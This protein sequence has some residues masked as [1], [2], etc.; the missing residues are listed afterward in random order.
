[1]EIDIVGENIAGERNQEKKK[2]AS[3]KTKEKVKGNFRGS[4]GREQEMDIDVPSSG[5][6]DLIQNACRRIV[7][8]WGQ[9]GKGGRRGKKG[10]GAR[11]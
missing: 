7:C 9:G 6:E 5:R 11:R 4:E 10:T 3:P 1:M 2:K 8:S